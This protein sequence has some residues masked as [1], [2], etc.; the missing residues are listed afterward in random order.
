VQRRMDINEQASAKSARE[1]HINAPS[2]VVW[3]LLANVDGWP[4]WNPAVSRAHLDGPFAP[5]SVFRWKSGGSSL[6]SVIKEVHRPNRVIWTGKTL[7]V[8]AVHV[9]NL[10]PLGEGVL[11]K[12]SESFEGWLVRLFRPIFQRLLDNALEQV[13]QS[14]K[15]AA[16]SAGRGAAA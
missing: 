2:E 13:L 8:T 4:Q 1:R 15:A 16:E 5:G 11:V 7:G 10:S 14:L 3:A 12:T 6:V 9:W